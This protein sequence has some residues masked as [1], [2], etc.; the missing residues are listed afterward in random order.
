M[1]CLGH[2]DEEVSQPERSSTI[3][4][5]V[6]PLENLMRIVAP[7]LGLLLLTACPPPEAVDAGAGLTVELLYPEP[8]QRIMANEDGSIDILGVVAIGGLELTDPAEADSLVDGQGHWHLNAEGS[9]YVPSFNSSA[10]LH[11]ESD[12]ALAPV[13]SERRV[14]VKVDLHDN[15]HGLLL[16]DDDTIPSDQTEVVLVPY[17]APEPAGD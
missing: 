16:L 8:D 2:D 5:T 7:F 3:G 6:P 14:L 9:G 1:S 15:D 13:D 17:E 11:L 4:G 12:D 10:V